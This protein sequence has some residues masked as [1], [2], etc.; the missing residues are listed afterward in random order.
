MLGPVVVEFLRTVVRDTLPGLEKGN[1]FSA[2]SV[3]AREARPGKRVVLMDETGGWKGCGTAWKLAEQGHEVFLVTPDALVGKELQ[4]TSADVPL[5]RTLR[6]L[7]VRFFTETSVDRWT[8][9]G[10]VLLSHLTGETESV[11][12]D[13]LV[14]ASTNTAM[15][16]LA[17]ELAAMGIA[18]TEIGDGVG[19]RQAAYAFYEGRVAGMGL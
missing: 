9:D 19:P 10:A 3:M 12:A 1:V 6:R 13:S 14:I 17:L 5:R 16:W 2:E 4:R 8:G 15:N 7:G 18:F 11:A